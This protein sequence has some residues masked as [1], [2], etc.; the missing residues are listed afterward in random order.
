MIVNILSIAVSVFL[1]VCNWKIFTKAGQEGWKSI[2]PIY[3][4]VVMCQ[5]ANIPTWWVILMIVPLANFVAAF[6]I[7]YKFVA[8]FGKGVGFYIGY[9]LCS[10]IFCAI[11]AFDKK[12]VY[13]GKAPTPTP[14]TAGAAPAAPAADPWVSGQAP[15][16]PATPATPAAPQQG[17]PPM[18]PTQPDNNNPFIQQPGQPQA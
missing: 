13:V 11:L 15:A 18:Q 7:S 2:I 5:I 10:P 8:A 3:N 4:M 1:I 9:L 16:A 6:Y 12:I 17:I 14:A